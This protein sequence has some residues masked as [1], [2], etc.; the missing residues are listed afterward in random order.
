MRPLWHRRNAAAFT[1]I[2]L[3]VVIAIIAV[4]AALLLPALTRGKQRAQRV[5]CI[6][7]LRE[8]GTA[9]QMFAHDH[10][11][12]FPMQ[13]STADGGSLEY[14]EAGTAISGTFYFS[15][16]H[17]QTLANELVVPRILVCPS[18]QAREPAASFG[19]LQNSNVSYF[20][21]AYADY[22]LPPSVL[23]GDRNVTNSGATASLVR[24]ATGLRWTAEMHAFKGDVLFADAHV[25]Q[26]NN[27]AVQLPAETA[28]TTVLF[29]PAVPAPP[30]GPSYS[31]PAGGS[32]PPV[33]AQNYDPPVPPLG[34]SPAG[35]TPQ[36]AGLSSPPPMRMGMSSSR[37]QGHEGSAS[38]TIIETS[39]R[40]TNGV[41]ATDAQPAAAPAAD[42]EPEPPL[43][44]LMGAARGVVGKSSWWLW[45]LLLLLIATA[46]YVYSRRKMRARRRRRA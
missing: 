9:F 21:G 19:A 14:V 34:G 30:S 43:L 1:L 39:A 18:D 41:A 23:A 29:L 28:P 22:N 38:E 44:W 42:D 7:N 26:L 33:P 35:A 2:E 17:L 11:G 4:L 46:I 16:R 37:M 45:L 3:L 40:E 8:I 12:R 13:L 20:V 36:A 10:Q 25:E 31:S 27:D 15:Y 32:S 24:G 5:Q 6:N